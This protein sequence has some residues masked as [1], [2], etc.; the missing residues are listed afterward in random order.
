M[1]FTINIQDKIRILCTILVLPAIGMHFCAYNE[2]LGPLPPRKYEADRDIAIYDD[3]P[4]TSRKLPYSGKVGY[5]ADLKR[6]QNLKHVCDS[7][8]TNEKK[9]QITV[10]CNTRLQG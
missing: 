1:K 2:N 6:K 8:T 5:Y 3:L 7:F 10:E 4:P 9:V